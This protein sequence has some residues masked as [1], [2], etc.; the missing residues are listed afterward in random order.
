MLA[1]APY[2][3]RVDF[4]LPAQMR[5]GTVLR[6]N[7]YRPDDGGSGTY[8]VLLTRLP[9]G[10]DLPSGS[11]VLD[12]VQAALRGY[13]VVVQDVRGT[14]NSGG[15]WLPLA[16][17]SADG[18][19]TVA[20]AASLPGAN[21]IVGM[22]GASYYGFTQWAAAKERP[23]A[24]RAM[25]PMITWDEPDDGVMSRDGVL[26]LGL[27]AAWNLQTGFDQ[28]ARRHRGNLP[29]LGA[30]YRTLVRE[31][32]ALPVAGYAELPL[33]GFG[34]LAR[35]DMAEPMDYYVARLHE[36]AAAETA[37][38]S[39][40]YEHVNMPVLHI[41]GWYDVFL[42]GTLRNF[43][44]MR[45]RGN[46]HQRLLIGPWTHGN[47][48]HVLGD[49]DFGFGASGVL[50]DLQIDLMRYQL[51]FFDRWL[52]D[53]RN[54]FDATAPVKYFLMGSNQWKSANTWP[55]EEAGERKWYL[56]S[57]GH[58]NSAH[59]DG[60]LSPELPENDE[61]DTYVYDPANP[62]PTIG[63]ATLMHP[64]FRAG[65]RDQRPIESRTDVL[66][67]TSAPL[68]SLLEVAGPVRV[69]LFVA[70][71][72]PDTDF[73]ARLVDVYP[74]GAAVNITDGIVRMRFREGRWTTA[75]PLVPGYVYGISIDL[76]ATGIVFLTGHRLRVDITSSNFP[77]WERNLNMGEDNL[78]ATEMR[79]AHQ[80][81][82]HDRE[83][84][85]CLVLSVIPK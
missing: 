13:V 56:S 62:V 7:V 29:A 24:L 42:N 17:E 1:S 16:H 27:Q 23:A 14:F 40:A 30:A 61:S 12:P 41:G 43:N 77:R 71:D 19:D 48:G 39:S 74:D 82:L 54:G 37:T 57:G 75:A 3:V 59:G 72:A 73:V 46:P 44:G 63:G 81:I 51:Q 33:E 38:V 36:R 8:P 21:G 32:D 52:K 85:S 45:Q 76:W 25:A 50:M 78:R 49:L 26:E 55:P 79:R 70:T 15:E 80:T 5:D 67:Y 35:A 6:A 31:M 20:W 28:L 83:H 68:N 34:P 2:G 53:E 69:D 11:N 65:P 18:A 22:Y 66:V 60:V 4:N 64:L 10:K 58:A 47:V 84:P 9:Y